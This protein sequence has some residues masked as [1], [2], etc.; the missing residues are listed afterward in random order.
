LETLTQQD[1]RSLGHQQR[2]NI[3]PTFA[4]LPE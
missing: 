1:K 2:V 4:M 3:A